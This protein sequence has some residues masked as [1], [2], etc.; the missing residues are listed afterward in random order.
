MSLTYE[1]LVRG[2]LLLLLIIGSLTDKSVHPHL[3]LIAFIVFE[4][5]VRKFE[6]PIPAKDHTKELEELQAKFDK[7]DGEFKQIK[8]DIG[9]AKIGAVIRKG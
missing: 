9:I 1:N 3:T 8:G 6:K 2:V 7:I 5:L 4:L